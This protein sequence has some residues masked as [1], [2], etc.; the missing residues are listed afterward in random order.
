M[1]LLSASS[2]PVAVLFFVVGADRG[3]AGKE[4]ADSHVKAVLCV[5]VAKYYSL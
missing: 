5:I 3:Q 4:G 2:I 1:S